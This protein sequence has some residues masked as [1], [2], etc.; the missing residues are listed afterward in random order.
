MQTQ[1]P[2]GLTAGLELQEQH[3]FRWLFFYP[4]LPTEEQGG[5]LSRP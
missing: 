2:P 3:M 5:L 1:N 4:A